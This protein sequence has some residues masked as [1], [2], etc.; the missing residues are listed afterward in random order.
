MG[1]QRS[2]VPKRVTREPMD[3]VVGDRMRARGGTGLDGF[4]LEA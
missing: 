2:L 4:L 1:E 3:E